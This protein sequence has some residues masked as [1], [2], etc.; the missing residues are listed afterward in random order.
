MRMIETIETRGDSVQDKI[1]N[2][3]KLAAIYFQSNL[4]DVTVNL[5]VVDCASVVVTGV[6]RETGLQSSAQLFSDTVDSAL[7]LTEQ[8][9]C[10]C[11]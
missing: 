7:R 6:N 8:H 5:M 11:I 4:N 10:A 2:I 1:D 9:L 3:R